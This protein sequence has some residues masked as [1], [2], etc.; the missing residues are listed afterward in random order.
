MVRPWFHLSLV[1]ERVAGVFEVNLY[2][3]PNMCSAALFPLCQ[4]SDELKQS[5]TRRNKVSGEFPS[6]I[7]AATLRLSVPHWGKLWRATSAFCL[8][9]ELSTVEEKKPWWH[10]IEFFTLLNFN[11]SFKTRQNKKQWTMRQRVTHKKL[12]YGKRGIHFWHIG[13]RRHNI[14]ASAA[15]ILTLLFS[16][17]ILSPST[18]NEKLLQYLFKAPLCR[19]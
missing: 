3:Y 12:H 6:G 16:K 2:M 17:P 15:F 14:S 9:R 4:C 13:S 1:T 7:P 5:G 10:H 18:W 19:V 8:W 11:N